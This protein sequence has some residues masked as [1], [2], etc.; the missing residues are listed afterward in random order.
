MARTNSLQW[1]VR[2]HTSQPIA[3]LQVPL[4]PFTL[5]I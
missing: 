1:Q 2:P 5:A 3:F 4:V